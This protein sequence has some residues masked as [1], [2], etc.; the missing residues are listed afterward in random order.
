[1]FFLGVLG[2]FWWNW[3][4]IQAFTLAKKV[5]YCLIPASSPFFSGYFGDGFLTN[6][7]SRLASNHSLPDLNLSS[8]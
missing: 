3:D 7:L 1:V 8:S 6:Y 4:L 2:V 5:L